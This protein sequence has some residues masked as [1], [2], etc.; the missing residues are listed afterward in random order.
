M[1]SEDGYIKLGRKLI[2]LAEENQIYP[3][4]DHMWNCAVTAG[5]KMITVGTTW[6]QFKSLRDLSNDEKSAVLGFIQ[7]KLGKKFLEE[8]DLTG[9]FTR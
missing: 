9:A 7:S 5:N 1:L 8:T 4:D 3:K 6:T 2:D